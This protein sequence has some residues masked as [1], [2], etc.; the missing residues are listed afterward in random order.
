M[1]FATNPE[2]V[3][4]AMETVAISTQQPAQQEESQKMESSPITVPTVEDNDYIRPSVCPTITQ[5]II[6]FFFF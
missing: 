1:S 2:S 6:V 3:A 4:A 5:I